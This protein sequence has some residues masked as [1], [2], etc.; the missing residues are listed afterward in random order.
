MNGIG[1]RD[2]GFLT[3]GNFLLLC[4]SHREIFLEESQVSHILAVG[5]VVSCKTPRYAP[6]RL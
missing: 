5:P 2:F 4:N 6:V 3:N 1:T